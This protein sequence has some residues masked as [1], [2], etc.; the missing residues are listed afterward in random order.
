MS[1]RAFQRQLGFL[2]YSPLMLGLVCLLGALVYTAYVWVLLPGHGQ[3]TIYW[4]HQSIFSVPQRLVLGLVP[5]GVILI[6]GQFYILRDQ[7]RRFAV[8][9]ILVLVLIA[10]WMLSC[11]VSLTTVLGRYTFHHEL[12]TAN[13]VY[14]LDSQWK[15][16]VGG[17]SRAVYWLWV[18]DDT[19]WIC[20]IVHAERI[21]PIYQEEDYQTLETVLRLNQ[22]TGT[23]EFIL[24]EDV[25]FSYPD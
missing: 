20:R 4:F 14:R 17:A 2:K 25:I 23:V 16:G 6:V 1:H 15:V 21:P 9:P 12:V 22:N 10:A 18:C 11:I 3:G 5:F 8:T 13:H 7:R 19:G 24:G